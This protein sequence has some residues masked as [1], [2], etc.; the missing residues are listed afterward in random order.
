MK[1][2]PDPKIPTRQRLLLTARELFHAQGYSATGMA[3]IL[4]EAQVNSGSLYH[5]FKSKEDLLIGVLELYRD[6]IWPMLIQPVVE[7]HSD[8]LDRVFGLLEVYRAQLLGSE[9]QSSCPI[10]NLALELSEFQPRARELIEANFEQWRTIVRG[11]LLDAADQ[12]PPSTDL[13]RLA[14]FI[15]T[16]MEGGVMLSRSYRD[17]GPFDA[18]VLSLRDYLQHFESNRDGEAVGAPSR[19]K[20]KKS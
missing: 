10:G 1:T 13:D 19:E 2:T 9:F 14:T 5:Y 16:T 18:A 6:N 20:G 8:P 4:R 11:W 15:L 3:Q 17:V 12:F 7:R